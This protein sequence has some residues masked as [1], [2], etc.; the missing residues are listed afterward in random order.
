MSTSPTSSSTHRPH[1]QHINLINTTSTS[2]SS[3]AGLL[4]P[5]LGVIPTIILILIVP[6]YLWTECPQWLVETCNNVHH[7]TKHHQLLSHILIA[8]E[9]L[10]SYRRTLQLA[11]I[12]SIAVA[13]LDSCRAI[14]TRTALAPPLQVSGA[15]PLTTLSCEY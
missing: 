9:Q 13:Q 12:V 1:H 7:H 8:V 3:S 5:D 15:Q 14:T 11:D 2:S 6:S 4:T 10:N